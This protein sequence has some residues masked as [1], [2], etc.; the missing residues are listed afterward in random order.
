[1]MSR[2][3]NARVRRFAIGVAAVTTITVAS[4]GETS[5]ASARIVRMP[6]AALPTA[7]A[8]IPG[9]IPSNASDNSITCPSAT[10]CFAVGTKQGAGGHYSTFAHFWNGTSWATQSTPTVSGRETG[11]S[12][13]SCPSLTLCVAV[14]GAT[15]ANTGQTKVLAMRWN[16]TSWASIAIPATTSTSDKLFS[17]SCASATFCAA[18]GYS[19]AGMIRGFYNGSQWTIT[20]IP[21]GA[22]PLK[23]VYGVSCTSATFCVAVGDGYFNSQSQLVAVAQK[24]DGVT[25]TDFVLPSLGPLAF[26]QAVS[27][28]SAASCVAVGGTGFSDDPPQGDPITLHWDGVAWTSIPNP[29]SKPASDPTLARSLRS[30]SCVTATSCVAVGYSLSAAPNSRVWLTENWNGTAWTFV[31]NSSPSG[32]ESFTTVSCAASMCMAL[33]AS[34]GLAIVETGPTADATRAVSASWTA[35]ENA[36]LQQIA[37]YLNTTPDGAQKNAVYL[38]GFLIGFT[39]STPAPQALPASG[40]AATYITTWNANELSVIDHV[41]TKFQLDDGDATRLSVALLDFLLALG[42]H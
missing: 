4:V 24:W 18:V 30:V 3:G 39:P 10:L 27:C 26:L 36:R 29:P 21:D 1:M 9:A 25:W 7:W 16:G 17:V 19:D 38:M 11:L 37:T 12:S 23:R 14:G 34:N 28:T 13:I 5:A 32:Q 20:T 31:Q 15:D 6:V 41:K 33:G 8:V 22:L 35:S 42:G 40:T 2:L